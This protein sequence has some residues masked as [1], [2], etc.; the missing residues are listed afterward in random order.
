[1]DDYKLAFF[2]FFVDFDVCD[3]GPG[4][5]QLEVWETW[6]VAKWSPG[7]GWEDVTDEEDPNKGQRHKVP[8]IPTPARYPTGT[9]A[10]FGIAK[11]KNAQMWKCPDTII[12]T[13][14]PATEGI[15]VAIG[16]EPPHI[17]QLRVN[18]EVIVTDMT[19]INAGCT[20]KH[21]ITIGFDENGDLVATP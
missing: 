13:D 5:C 2:P 10:T 19:G 6:K 15:F 18:Q 7:V 20:A 21:T 12:F 4:D 14:I 1:V 16:K 17:F 3:T 8:Y 9:S 11:R